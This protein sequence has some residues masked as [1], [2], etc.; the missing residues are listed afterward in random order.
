MKRIATESKMLVHKWK[1]TLIELL[2]VIAIIAILAGL[3]L[4]ALQTVMKRGRSIACVNNLKQMGLNCASYTNAYNDYITPCIWYFKPIK[5]SYTPMW[6]WIS[7]GLYEGNRV[8]DVQNNPKK[9]NYKLLRC[10]QDQHPK[11]PSLVTGWGDAFC[12]GHK[13]WRI[14]YG[15]AK[16]AGYAENMDATSTLVK[17]PF[18]VGSIKYSPSSSFL[19]SDRNATSSTDISGFLE[20]GEKFTASTSNIIK[21]FPRRHNGKDNFLMVDGHVQTVNP[22]LAKSQHIYSPYSR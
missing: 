1:F 16:T 19:G 21:W 12:K 10:P 14:S 7:V 15:W 20:V 18:K 22:H 5:S 9:Y 11:D 2:V 4:P 8:L 6:F 17:Y 13:E 3:L